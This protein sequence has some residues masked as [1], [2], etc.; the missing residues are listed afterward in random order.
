MSTPA[1]DN[2]S[3]IQTSKAAKFFKIFKYVWLSLGI[4][5]PILVE[6]ILLIIS[7]TSII[8]NERD[9]AIFLGFSAFMITY[10]VFC[11]SA[12]AFPAIFGTFSFFHI[13]QC[14]LTP[15]ALK[16]KTFVII[17]RILTVLFGVAS[18]VC[19]V[20]VLAGAISLYS[21]LRTVIFFFG[22]SIVLNLAVE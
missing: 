2:S 11:Y 5:S 22:G 19:A 4:V 7:A 9:N 18:I 15:K 10:L 14:C 12:L 6:I 8:L 21:Y 17:I 16:N 1:T 13:A 3:R 20:L